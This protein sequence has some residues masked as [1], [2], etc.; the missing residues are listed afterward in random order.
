MNVDTDFIDE[1]R[2]KVRSGDGGPGS[3]SFRREKFVPRGGPDGGNGG[4]GGDVTIRANKNVTTLI[5][6]RYKRHFSAENGKHG[7]GAMKNGIDGEGLTLDVPVGTV[8]ADA[9]THEVLADLTEDEST[10]VVCTGGRGGKGNAFFKGPA[11][12]APRFAQPG[13]EGSEH[14]LKLEMKLLSDIGLIGL[15]NAGKSSFITVVSNARPK[16]GNYPFTTLTPHLGVVRFTD[17]K[18]FVLSDLPGL[19]QNAHLGAGLGMRFLKHIERTRLLAHVVDVATIDLDNPFRDIDVIHEELEQF[20]AGLSDW[21]KVVLLSKADLLEPEQ[22]ERVFAAIAARY[23]TTLLVSSATHS[24]V[25]EAVRVLGA[26]WE[27]SLA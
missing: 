27:A 19:I 13:E 25:A 9:E 24:G 16:I 22:Q 15:P 11:R 4:R 3:V 12:Q 1:V 26:L 18:E 5:A 23:P 8:I 10:F 21:V 2:I 20:R 7:S 17:E 14:M 6:Y